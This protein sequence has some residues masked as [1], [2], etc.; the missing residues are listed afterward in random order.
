MKKKTGKVLFQQLSET[1]TRRPYAVPVEPIAE[2]PGEEDELG[3]GDG[4]ARPLIR[5]GAEAWMQQEEARALA[6]IAVPEEPAR[7]NAPAVIRDRAGQRIFVRYEDGRL[8]LSWAA[9]MGLDNTLYWSPQQDILAP[10]FPP[11]HVGVHIT[12][13]GNTWHS[14]S[15]EG[16][17]LMW[18]RERLEINNRVE[19]NDAPVANAAVNQ[20]L[21]QQLNL[22]ADRVP[23][24][25]ARAPLELDER[26]F[27][28]HNGYIILWTSVPIEGRLQWRMTADP[29][30][31][32]FQPR[33]AGEVAF[34][35]LGSAW[36]SLPAPDGRF[37][38]VRDREQHVQPDVN[39]NV[40]TT[41]STYAGIWGSSGPSVPATSPKEENGSVTKINVDTLS[42]ALA[43]EKFSRLYPEGMKD[44]KVIDSMIDEYMEIYDE[45]YDLIYTHKYE[46][47]KTPAV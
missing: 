21:N 23:A 42:T 47:E 11:L 25:P 16:G 36:V 44:D 33:R 1:M 26:F 13:N 8:E 18:V 20:Q 40:G 14:R 32:Q 3:E 10:N 17:G 24:P 46:E 37:V 2:L 43:N 31:P 19:I 39:V 9:L 38:W 29:N 4:E 27:T 35:R 22:Q 34:T 12:W 7:I 15:V 5:D 45:L 30:A 28:P 41:T 6:E